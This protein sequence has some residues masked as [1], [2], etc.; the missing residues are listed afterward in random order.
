MCLKPLAKGLVLVQSSPLFQAAVG[1]NQH[2]EKAE[3]I[4]VP[5]FVTVCF[6]A[7]S[8]VMHNKDI[9][10]FSCAALLLELPFNPV[11]HKSLFLYR[12]PAK[13]PKP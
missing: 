6:V 9:A 1:H 7:L 12:I 8:S 11:K 4:I 5:S 10:A 3:S 2:M 13:V